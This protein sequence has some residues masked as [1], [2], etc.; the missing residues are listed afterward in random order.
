MNTIKPGLMVLLTLLI[1]PL[2]ITQANAEAFTTGKIK[3]SGAIV[4]AAQCQ[5]IHSHV[6]TALPS[7]ALAIQ[8]E[9]SEMTSLVTASMD[10]DVV[11]WRYLSSTGKGI[12]LSQDASHDAYRITLSYF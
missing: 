12:V 11:V 1:S 10:A 5:P 3:F 7:S 2:V 9:R 4:E 8:C 6:H